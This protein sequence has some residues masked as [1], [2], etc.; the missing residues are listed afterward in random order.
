M[1][2]QFS[3]PTDFEFRI[4]GTGDDDNI[5][6]TATAGNLFQTLTVQNDG[7]YLFGTKNDV[8]VKVWVKSA[9]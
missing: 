6:G 8:T 3:A 2:V 7:L 5:T 9:G 1:T 4:F